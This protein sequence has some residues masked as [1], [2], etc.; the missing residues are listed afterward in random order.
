[1]IHIKLIKNLPFVART[2]LTD[3]NVLFESTDCAHSDVVSL[4]V[5]D[6]ATFDQVFIN[7]F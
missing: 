1:M 3:Q 4:D 7:W 6:G 5:I 2:T